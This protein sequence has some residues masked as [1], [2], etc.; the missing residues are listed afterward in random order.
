[1]VRRHYLDLTPNSL[2]W[3][4]RKYMAAWKRELWIKSLK[5]YLIVGTTSP[6]QYYL[7]VTK[8]HFHGQLLYCCNVPLSLISLICDN[9]K[10]WLLFHAQK[11]CNNCKM[12]WMSHVFE[13]INPWTFPKT[14]HVIKIAHY[15]ETLVTS[16]VLHVNVKAYIVKHY[17]MCVW[18]WTSLT[19]LLRKNGK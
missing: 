1:M 4:T 13:R 7:R 8:T 17:H 11:L 10:F 6:M 2:K 14:C 19:Y 18:L 16:L 5:A 3:F 12:C 15:C 9:S